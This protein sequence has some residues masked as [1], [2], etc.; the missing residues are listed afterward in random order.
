MSF[1]KFRIDSAN[2]NKSYFTNR[3]D[4][5][6]HITQST[7]LARYCYMFLRTVSTFSFKL[8]PSGPQTALNPYSVS[9]EDYI[10]Q[11]PDYNTHPHQIHKE[12]QR[13]LATFQQSYLSSL[14]APTGKDDNH[15]PLS[16]DPEPHVTVFPMI[17]AGQFGVRE[18]ENVL[19]LLLHNL[20]NFGDTSARRPLLDLTSGYF[21]LYRPY[22]DAILKSSSLDTRIVCSAPKVLPF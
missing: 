22:R 4:R 12:V 1:S 20:D 16:Q 13:A 11:W 10:L 19:E 6:L 7:T 3:Q 21:G 17:Q 2:L 14:T 18:E 8:L 15:T 5:Y 9:R